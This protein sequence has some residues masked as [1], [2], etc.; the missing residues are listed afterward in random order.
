[1]VV[2][3]R[4]ETNSV[5]VAWAAA[6]SASEGDSAGPL[7]QNVGGRSQWLDGNQGGV[8]WQNFGAPD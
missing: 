6:K 7:D 3:A 2:V 4:I 1:M 8:E 5:V